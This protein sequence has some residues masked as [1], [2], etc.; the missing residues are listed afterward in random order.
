MC[1]NP[2]G[3]LVFR[4][5]SRETIEVLKGIEP[6]AVKIS[7]VI[8]LRISL[9]SLFLFTVSELLLLKLLG[10]VKLVMMERMDC[11][12]FFFKGYKEFWMHI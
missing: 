4:Q 9:V 7:P 5:K 8:S 3:R 6:G 1:D 12:G 11:F 10:G 2:V